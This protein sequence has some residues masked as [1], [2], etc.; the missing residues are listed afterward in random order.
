MTS[1][2]RYHP[3]ERTAQTRAG[4]LERADRASGLIGAIVP[5]VA[6]DYLAHQPM[7][8]VAAAD[9]AGHMWASLLTG[10]PGFAVAD[11]DRA[12]VISAL[13]LPGDPLEKALRSRAKVGTIALEP[14][15]HRRMRVNGRADPIPG[16]LRI[17]ADQVFSNCGKYI[18]TRTPR[19]LASP[20]PPP[21]TVAGPVLTPQQQRAVAGADTFFIATRSADG[22]ADASHRGGNPGFVEV[23]SPTTLRWPDYVGNAM[24]M[25]LGNLE[26][27]PSAG[28][29]LIDWDAGTTWQ[30][31]G[32]AHVDWQPPSTDRLPGSERVINFQL[33][34]VVQTIHAS[35]LTWSAPGYSR[36]NPSLRPT[37]QD[38]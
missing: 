1:S 31:T 37:G 20:L 32:T 33:T 34:R 23:V 7:V 35:P 28:L 24:M 22:D 19:R 26:Q 12:I 15:S 14:D 5:P 11:G 30:L 18:Q 6:A 8:V 38:G 13:P 16:G 3:G 2:G 29:L 21:Q 4:V 25:T 17:E 27:D 10:R 36:F 9:E